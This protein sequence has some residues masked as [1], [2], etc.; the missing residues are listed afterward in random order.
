[1]LFN[2]LEFLFFFPAVFVHYY[3]LRQSQRLWMLLIASCIFYMVYR[4]E[5]ILI[6]LLTIIIDYFAAFQIQ[7][8]AGSKRKQWL[9]AS[10]IAN[11]SILVFF[12]YSNFAIANWNWLN[13]KINLH[14]SSPILNI[15]LPIGLSFHTFQAM[16]YTIEVYRGKHEAEK[17]FGVY[18]LYVLFFPQMVA[19]PIER[20]QN[21]LP[22]LKVKH[23]FNYTEVVEGLKQVLWGFFKKLV[24]A[25]RLALFVNAVF[26]HPHDYSGAS[27]WIAIYFFAFQIY[28]DFSGY[29]DIALGCARMLGIRLMTNFNAPYLSK[30][31]KEF[32]S[33]WHISLSTWF[34]DYVYIP[35]GG[36]KVSNL[37]WVRNILIVF[38]LSGFWHGANWTFIVWGLLHGLYLII[39]HFSPTLSPSTSLRIN[40]ERT[41]EASINYPA[42]FFKWFLTFN[43]VCFAWIFFRAN[44]ISDCWMIIQH[45][46]IPDFNIPKLYEVSS[47]SQFYLSFALIFLLMTFEYFHQRK[48]LFERIQ[49][50]PMI[51][52]WSIYIAIFW[53]ILK[54]GMFSQQQ[55]IYFVF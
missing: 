37:K 52:R 23:Q 26:D 7:K 16:S 38:V 31:V 10:I 48:N 33:R 24:I 45:A 15:A 30:S 42:K 53:I 39:D 51:P 2:S 1:M 50:M 32:W 55:F 12:K 14:L 43:L 19:G 44:S 13:D 8:H 11:V 5:Y 47:K 22:Q 34:R 46:S 40:S 36:N 21:I 25:D 6:I 9:L 28:C 35:L 49:V 41:L 27:V 17:H 18:A 4:P 3:F 20:P 54:F 29:S